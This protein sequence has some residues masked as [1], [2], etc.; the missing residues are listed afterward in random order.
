M[1]LEALKPGGEIRIKLEKVGGEVVHQ[2]WQRSQA[3]KGVVT[4]LRAVAKGSDDGVEWMS[5]NPKKWNLDDKGVP[6]LDLMKLDYDALPEGWKRNSDAAAT[7]VV[8]LV[9][10]F[11]VWSGGEIKPEMITVMGRF[12]HNKYT[13][14]QIS[15]AQLVVGKWPMMF[16]EG[17]DVDYSQ[18]ILTE[19]EKDDVIVIGILKKLTEFVAA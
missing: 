9:I 15:W 16:E 10:K 14:D 4:W 5:A 6:M 11:Y 3:D 13:F 1:N 19:Q 17:K 2:A 12:T 7:F 18:L 8:D